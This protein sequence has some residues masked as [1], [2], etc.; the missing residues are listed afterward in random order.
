MSETLL[1]EMENNEWSEQ[2]LKDNGEKFHNDCIVVLR[3]LYKGMRLTAKNVNDITNMAD[4]GRRL[5][6][7]IKFRKDC[8]KQIRRKPEGGMEGVEYWLDIP[9]YPTKNNVIERAAKV[10][11]LMQSV[12]DLKQGGLFE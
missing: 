9:P 2:F 6:D 12:G 7:I 3:L 8:K 1:H 5:R 11:N 4:G 10:I